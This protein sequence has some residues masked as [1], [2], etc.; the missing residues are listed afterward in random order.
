MH[1]GPD[2]IHETGL[3]LNMYAIDE[4]KILFGT[5]NSGCFCYTVKG[6]EVDIDKINEPIFYI[7]YESSIFDIKNKC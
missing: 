7:D 3:I 5:H 1:V 4:E 2:K 6:I